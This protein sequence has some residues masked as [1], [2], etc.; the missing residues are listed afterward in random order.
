[1]SSVAD[2]YDG[3]QEIIDDSGNPDVFKISPSSIQDFF[4]ETSR[5]YYEQVEGNEKAFQGST[6]TLLGTLV[7][8]CAEKTTANPSYYITPEEID[9]FLATQIDVEYDESTIKAL[10]PAMAGTLINNTVSNPDWDVIES[11]QF[12]YAKLN[13]DVYIGGTFDCLRVDPAVQGGLCVVDF[14]TAGSKPSTLSQKYRLQAYAY[15]WMLR[16]QGKN[17]TSIELCYVVRPTKT[18]PVRYFNFKEFYTDENHAYIGRILKLIADSI[19]LYKHNPDLRRIIAQDANYEPTK[20]T[21]AFP[22]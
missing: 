21:V 10:L 5:Y 13:D 7:H 6:S 22:L 3:M 1:M 4:T 15:A 14:K 20:P 8:H 17:I 2:Y 11:E 18:L 9:E 19:S 16:E 12:N